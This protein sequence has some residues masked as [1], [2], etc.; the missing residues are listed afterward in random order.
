MPPNRFFA[1][2]FSSPRVSVVQAS[3]YPL[4]S[5]KYAMCSSLVSVAI[6]LVF[7]SAL[8]LLLMCR[9]LLPK[10]EKNDFTYSSIQFKLHVN[11]DDRKGSPLGYKLQMTRPCRCCCLPIQCR[12]RVIAKGIPAPGTGFGIAESPFAGS[13]GALSPGFRCGNGCAIYAC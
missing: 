9:R 13:I 4:N 6:R 3:L 1:F 10:M 2:C 7:S 8:L 5:H 11:R 12:Q